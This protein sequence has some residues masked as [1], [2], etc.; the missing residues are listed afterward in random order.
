MIRT[1]AVHLPLF[2]ILSLVSAGSIAAATP[3]SVYVLARGTLADTSAGVAYTGTLDGFI[4]A[5]DLATGATLWM[6]RAASLPI[7]ADN[8]FVVAQ[9]EI[10]PTGSLIIEVVDVRTGSSVSSATIPL[11]PG[12]Q[13]TVTDPRIT[14]S[15]FFRAA[16]LPDAGD[17]VVSWYYDDRVYSGQERPLRQFA[18]SAR[19]NPRSGAVLTSTSGVATEI[20]LWLQT[21]SVTPAAPWSSGSVTAWTSTSGGAVTL[22][23]TSTTTGQPLPDVFLSANAQYVLL[24]EPSI[25]TR[26]LM[27]V[28]RGTFGGYRSRIF[29]IETGEQLSDVTVAR[30][31]LPFAVMGNGIVTVESASQASHI[32]VPPALV[33]YSLSSGEHLWT[34]ARRDPDFS[35]PMPSSNTRRQRSV[36]H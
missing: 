15:G 3:A 12:V 4:Q 22:K 6:S 13:A 35:G 8:D 7:G 11:P 10:S 26:Y 19:V 18:G 24:V 21:Y 32:Y 34:V 27:V 31:P 1:A 36:R 17:F 30:A 23:R 33:A 5:V 29:A 25:D 2:A 20:P 28:E 16:A 14:G 9:K